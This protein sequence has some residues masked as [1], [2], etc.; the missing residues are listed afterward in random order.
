MWALVLL[1]IALAMQWSP[2]KSRGPSVHLGIS[3]WSEENGCAKSTVSWSKLPQ[4]LIHHSHMK[5][6]ETFYL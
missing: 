4:D 5:S 1:F 3:M 2:V 6:K